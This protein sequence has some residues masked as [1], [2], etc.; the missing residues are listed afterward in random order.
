M[1]AVVDRV[2]YPKPEDSDH[3]L[4]S[5]VSERDGAEGI[6]VC[7][8][9][10]ETAAPDLWTT[11]GLSMGKG[12]MSGSK[13]GTLSFLLRPSQESAGAQIKHRSVATRV[14][15]LPVANTIFHNGRAS[16]LLAQRWVITEIPEPINHPEIRLT[17][18]A[19]LPQQVLRMTGIVNDISH[20]SG[21]SLQAPVEPIT[22]PRIV[23]AAMGNIIRSIQMSDRPEDSVPAS[24]ELEKAVASVYQTSKLSREIFGVWA[25]VTPREYRDAQTH[26]RATGIQG[27]IDSGSRLHKVLSGGG[28]WGNKQGLL[29]LDPDSE[30]NKDKE[31]PRR[32]FGDGD[33]V[34][35]E[36]LEALGQV[37]RPGDVVSFWVYFAEPIAEKTESNVDDVEASPNSMIVTPP[38]IVFGTMPSTM[39]LMPNLEAT[40]GEATVSPSYTVI[41]NHFGMLS[42]QG[43]SMK[44][45]ATGSEGPSA[46]SAEKGGVVVQTKLDVPY[47]R[48]SIAEKGETVVHPLQPFRKFMFGPKEHVQNSAAASTFQ[49]HPN[50]YAGFKEVNSKGKPELY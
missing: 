24:T 44:I 9:D 10:S 32:L 20:Q 7:I 29:A 21:Y 37:V 17:E 41:E 15:Q 3:S 35:A 46:L 39:D 28:G 22:A 5:K 6:S 40:S 14:V 34:E 1:A 47:S 13:Q 45:S 36:K 19:S 16:T 38:S 12:T 33:D 18:E 48:V 42:E 4:F 11:R 50:R 26:F 31:A 30:Y 2:T 27:L 43:M 23:D 8:L 25:L 49:A